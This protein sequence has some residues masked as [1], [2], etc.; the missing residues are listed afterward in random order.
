MHLLGIDTGESFGEFRTKRI[1][2]DG[3]GERDAEDAAGGSEAV[4]VRQICLS[5]RTMRA[6]AQVRD[7]DCRSLI[8]DRD[9]S[10]KSDDETGD[11]TAVS[12]T[13]LPHQL[14]TLG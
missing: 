3:I 8:G 11:G 12:D 2:E 5:E 10:D 14:R 4:Q 1:L 6:G 7:T 9:S 13:V